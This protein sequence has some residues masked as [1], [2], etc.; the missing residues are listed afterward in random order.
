MSKTDAPRE[1]PT[2]LTG[3]H[4]ASDAVQMILAILFVGCWIA[5]SFFLRV[6]TLLNVHVPLIVRIPI[7]A[8][9][10]VI[11]LLLA[12]ASHQAVFVGKDAEHRVLR[13]GAFAIVRHPMYL[14]E[15]L[16]FFGVLAF[17]LS[18]AA[19]A[20]WLALIVALHV[21]ARTEEKLLLARFG[22]EYA[23][24]MRDVPMWLP[25]LRRRGDRNPRAPVG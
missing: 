1:N 3:E 13:E 2:R 6:S 22:D 7:G 20:F 24:Y 23:A 21:F 19:A 18:L 12:R 8:V 15:I 10:V 16:L 11:A 17:S 9:F 25:R 4:P 5:D 14:S